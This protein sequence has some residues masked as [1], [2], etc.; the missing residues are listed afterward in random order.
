[1]TAPHIL[2]VRFSSLGDLVLTTP[3]FRAIKRAH[4]SARITIL[5]RSEYVPLFAHNPRIARVIGW[6][7][8]TSLRSI[9]RELRRTEWTHRLD[10]HGSLRSHL[11]RRLVGGRW[12]G[13]PKRRLARAI[14]VRFKKDVYRDRRHVVE[15][16][17]DAAQGLGATP[18]NLPPEV[19]VQMEGASAADRFLR[20]SGIADRTL[21]AL[22]PGAAHFTKRW[23]EH[24]WVALTEMLVA[25]GLAVLVLGGKAE[26]EVADRLVAVAGRRGASAAGKFDL[27][28]TAALLKRVRVAIAGD[29]GVMHLAT[30]VQAP[31]VALLGPTV[32]GFG[33][34]PWNGRST[35]IER[36][37]D[38]RPCSKMGGPA[39]PLGHHHCLEW[40]TAED[41]AEAVRRLPQ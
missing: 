26:V 37:L 12:H 14:Q 18:D 16:Y 39:C 3:L 22:V 31:V 41:V 2:A 34:T 30:A 38:C 21:V 13:Y 11:V 29:T 23:P 20:E 9:T 1:M 8:E 36:D 32:R 33:F 19:F 25:R 28:G 24:H 4:P 15:R 6:D 5:T 27:A 40:I 10:L 7:G 35:I 17:F